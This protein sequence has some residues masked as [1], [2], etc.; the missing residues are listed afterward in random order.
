MRTLVLKG[1]DSCPI[2]SGAKKNNKLNGG[3]Y[4]ANPESAQSVT[5]FFRATDGTELMR[6]GG[7]SM[8][9]LYDMRIFGGA[10]VNGTGNSCE[11][12]PRI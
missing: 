4:L 10:S 2:A 11:D 8:H 7:L 5:M 12:A 6:T 1:S 3:C 9:T